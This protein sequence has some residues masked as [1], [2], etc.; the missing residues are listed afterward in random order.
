MEIFSL[1]RN[2]TGTF[3]SSNTNVLSL[4]TPV[5]AASGLSTYY[6]LPFVFIFR[7]DQVADYTDIFNICDRYKIVGASV[8]IHS[9]NTS[10]VYNGAMPYIDY[11]IDQDDDV[12]P[13]S[14]SIRQKMGV[15]QK[16]FN[17]Q[18]TLTVSTR[19]LCSGLVLGNAG[20]SGYSVPKAT[21][22]DTA[23][24]SVPHFGLKGIFRN[25]VSGAGTG[26]TTP[27][28][29]DVKLTMLCADLQ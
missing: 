21:W 22:I 3:I 24:S 29:F 6:D 13:T 20:G 12:A 23:Y 26:E 5:A 15:R 4:G 17:Q 19:P 27:F 25:V 28:T 18:G 8:K 11:A 16:G 14:S 7:L 9:G 2:S 10:N 1:K